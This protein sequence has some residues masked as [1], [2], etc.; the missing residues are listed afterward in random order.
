MKEAALIR[1]RCR[2]HVQATEDLAPKWTFPQEYAEAAFYAARTGGEW[3]EGA[4]RNIRRFVMEHGQ[5]FASAPD[6]HT[7][8][9]IHRIEI[10]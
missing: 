9:R 1:G 5:E 8:L 10:L 3:P 2:Y 6:F 7:F 4:G